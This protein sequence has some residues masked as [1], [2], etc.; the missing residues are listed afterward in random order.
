[1][2]KAKDLKPFVVE[3]ITKYIFIEEG[4][5]EDAFMQDYPNFY[6]HFQKYKSDLA[7]R[8]Q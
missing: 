8:Y 1:M 2:I 6:Q 4:L 5:Q 7:N 3:N